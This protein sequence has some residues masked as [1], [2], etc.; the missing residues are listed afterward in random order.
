MVLATTHFDPSDHLTDAEGI[1]EYLRSAFED[2]DPTVIA[3]ALG[4]VAR[5]RG[6]TEL[7]RDTGL[8]RQALYKALRSDGKP[9]FATVLG[10][11]QALGLRLVPERVPA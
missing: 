9:G 8:S 7:A 6:M 3:D 5:A 11:V 1:E 4:V 2:G 10:V